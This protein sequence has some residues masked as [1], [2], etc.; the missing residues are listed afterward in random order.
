MADRG[1]QKIMSLACEADLVQYGDTVRGAGYTKTQEY[2]DTCYGVMLDLVRDEGRTVSLLDFGCGTGRFLD[3]IRRIGREG[4]AYSGLDMSEQALT[5][6]RAKFPD[7]PFICMD[8]LASDDHLPE[9]D[10]VVMNGLLNWRGP[11]S[12]AEMT[13]YWQRLTSVAFRHCRRGIAFNTM[14][15]IVDWQREDLFHL[16]FDAMASFVT[17]NLSRDFVV[18]HD[19][20]AYEYTTYVYRRPSS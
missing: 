10:Y 6:A 1:F 2:A 20:G 7:V 15:T 4:V 12:F 13:S 11:L 3:Y 5:L 18:R 17:A 14:S 19:Y 8:V 16:P 9:F